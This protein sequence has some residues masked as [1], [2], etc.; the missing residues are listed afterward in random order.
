MQIEKGRRRGSALVWI[1]VIVVVLCV[2]GGG[3]F[4]WKK[5]RHP[6]QASRLGGATATL[7][8]GNGVTLELVKIIPGEFT[9]GSPTD[10]AD[11][12]LSEDPPHKVTISKPFYIG[13]FEIAQA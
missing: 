1:V 12:D 6:R 4:Y 13:K 5:H 10:E 11:R 7:D 3:V 9:M 2:A 8:L